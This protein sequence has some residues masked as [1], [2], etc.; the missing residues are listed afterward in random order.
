MFKIIH[1]V[2]MMNET[3]KKKMNLRTFLCKKGI[4]FVVSLSSQF[5][6]RIRFTWE[7]GSWAAFGAAF[8]AVSGTPKTFQ[9]LK[10]SSPAAEATVQPSGLCRK[11]QTNNT[12]SQNSNH[13]Q[14]LYKHNLIIKIIYSP[15]PY[16]ELLTYAQWAQPSSPSTDTSTT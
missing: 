12:S 13:F 2:F 1:S 15:G 7:N 3:Q 16:I 6:Q 10:V 4:F 11:T 8:L 5:L 14:H 9:N